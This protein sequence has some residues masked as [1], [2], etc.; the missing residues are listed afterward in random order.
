MCDLLDRMPQGITLAASEYGIIGSRFPGLTIV[1]LVGLH[2]S[3]IAHHGF[4]AAYV[5]SRKPDV[6]WFPHSDY[7]YAVAT[8]LDNHAFQQ[9][10][11]YYPG[12]YDYGIALRKTSSSYASMKDAVKREFGRIY[13]EKHLADYIAEPVAALDKE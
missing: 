2:D 9:D 12:A 6:I 8:I 3:T 10:Y 4:S 13:P 7:T 11:E 1:D 5:C